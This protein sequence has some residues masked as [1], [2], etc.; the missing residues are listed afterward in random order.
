MTYY[1]DSSD[2]EEEGVIDKIQTEYFEYL[3]NE[4]INFQDIV[5]T[6]NP[7]QTFY[8]RIGLVLNHLADRFFRHTEIAEKYRCLK[9]KYIKQGDYNNFVEEAKKFFKTQSNIITID[10]SKFESPEIIQLFNNL[11]SDQVLIPECV[12]STS[13]EY[14]TQILENIAQD[15]NFLHV[16]K[17][18]FPNYFLK[19]EQSQNTSNAAEVLSFN[20]I[21]NRY[22]KNSLKAIIAENMKGANVDKAVEVKFLYQEISSLTEAWVLR[23]G[24]QKAQN[25]IVSLGS[26][27]QI[28]KYVNEANKNNVIN[29]AMS[30]LLNKPLD[31]GSTDN[32]LTDQMAQLFFVS[33]MARNKATVFTA[34]MFLDLLKKQDISQQDTKEALI[35]LFPMSMKGAIQCCRDLVNEKQLENIHYMDFNHE[36]NDQGNILLAQGKIWCAYS[37][38]MQQAQDLL[39]LQ[40]KVNTTT[41]FLNVTSIVKGINAVKMFLTP[42]LIDNITTLNQ[43][44][45]GFIF[46]II[47]DLCINLPLMVIRQAFHPFYKITDIL[48]TK[49]IIPEI[50]ITDVNITLYDAIQQLYQDSIDLYQIKG[51]DFEDTVIL[52]KESLREPYNDTKVDYNS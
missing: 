15:Q 27:D 30:L 21:I 47:F 10:D 11:F 40:Q 43:I 45:F 16:I 1:I 44:Q 34:L 4:I 49:T 18:T 20:K 19:L 8:Y 9:D 6:S 17:Q 28:F 5:Q 33:E 14:K 48:L 50:S 29:R 22:I 2:D 52:Q 42:T 35:D 23:P 3:V 39:K 37:A 32:Q 7:T 24:S 12:T 25:E 36:E 41:N 13:S 51:F 38:Q 46:A 31:I 26:Y